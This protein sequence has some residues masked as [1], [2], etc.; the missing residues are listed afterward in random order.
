MGYR[1]DWATVPQAGGQGFYR[2]SKM[3][4]RRVTITAADN[5]S[6]N[7]VGAFMI[8]AGFVVSSIL[9]VSTALGTG[10]V[11]NVGDSV[12]NR[13]VAASTIAAAGGSVATL[14]GSPGLMFKN[15]NETEIQIGIGTGAG[16]PAAGT[17]DLYLIGFID[18]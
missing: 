16:S 6:G 9:L 1:K 18:N 7:V 8:P 10:T 11:I 14:V 13:Y 5:V 3:L 4:G 17:I 12:I 15:V 2:T